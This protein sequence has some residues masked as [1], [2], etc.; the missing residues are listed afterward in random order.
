VS[1]SGFLGCEVLGL[2]YFRALPVIAER[3]ATWTIGFGLSCY[4]IMLAY[5]I[6]FNIGCYRTHGPI[7]LD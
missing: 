7:L 1:C 4:D 5:L 3:K 2:I 6:S